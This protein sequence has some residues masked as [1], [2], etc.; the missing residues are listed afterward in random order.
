MIIDIINIT[1]IM[2]NN[3][4]IICVCFLILLTNTS[5]FSC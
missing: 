4:Y 3:I 5:N 1:C 2:I